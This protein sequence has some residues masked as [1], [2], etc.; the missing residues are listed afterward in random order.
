MKPAVRPDL[1][2]VE[3]S[4]GLQPDA[5][6]EEQVGHLYDSVVDITVKTSLIELRGLFL[7]DCIMGVP[8]ISYQGVN[9]KPGSHT[10]REKRYHESRKEGPYDA[11]SYQA[12]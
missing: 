8:V 9:D 6:G 2:G 1:K 4:G 11:N 3:L 12:D 5:K 7:A 10:K